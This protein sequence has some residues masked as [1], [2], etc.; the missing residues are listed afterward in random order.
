M[1]AN[2][3]YRLSGSETAGAHNLEAIGS[4]TDALCEEDSSVQREEPNR[5]W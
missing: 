5:F 1:Y 3:A 2:T 4:P